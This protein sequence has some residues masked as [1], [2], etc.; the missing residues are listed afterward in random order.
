MTNNTV[1]QDYTI[2]ESFTLPSRGEIYS[3]SVNP[4][5][6]LRSMTTAEEM[7]RQAKTDSPYKQMSEVIEDCIVGS[8]PGISVYDM[9]LGDY[10]FLLHK[11]RVVTYGPEYK[12]FI[13]CP[14][15]G[16]TQEKIA[17]LDTLAVTEVDIED[18][19]N[20]LKVTLPRTKKEIE[21]KFTTPRMLDEIA[22]RRKDYARKNPDA[23]DQGLVY[24]LSYAIKSV[25]DKISTPAVYETFVKKLPMADVN[26]LLQK[27]DAINNK[28]GLDSDIICTCKECG[29]ET[30]T[31]FRLTSEFF[32]PTID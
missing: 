13:T 21:L 22:K 30:V 8:K 26:Y 27:I 24:T 17:D 1:E 28:I 32:G 4:E 16:N 3:T 7:K 9:C 12:M 20:S 15:C 31:P 2:A 6:K 11:L 25:D 5:I 29:F 10:E 18:F 19:K 23:L 14:S